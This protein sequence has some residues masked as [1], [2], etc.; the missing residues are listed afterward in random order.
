MK[1][2]ITALML[3]FVSIF[4]FSEVKEQYNSFPYYE[5]IVSIDGTPIDLKHKV[6][7]WSKTKYDR[8][9][10]IVKEESEMVVIDG[11]TWISKGE[12]GLCPVTFHFTMKFEFKEG[13]LRCVT[14][15]TRAMVVDGML[16]R[17]IDQIKKYTA[18]PTN[19]KRRDK[20]IETFHQ[21]LLIWME[22]I[23]EASTELPESDW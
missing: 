13:R 21:K 10:F 4:S 15:V 5:Y 14:E 7:N 23:S 22:D 8:T 12:M 19:S 3:C 17:S 1:K 2:F 11:N 6:L 20:E 18:R 9:E 16:P